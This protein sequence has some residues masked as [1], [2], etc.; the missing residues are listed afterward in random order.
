[1]VDEHDRDLALALASRHSAEDVAASLYRLAGAICGGAPAWDG[2]AVEAQLRW[3]ALA[4]RGPG[5]LE[6]C[7]GASF[8]DAGR[9]LCAAFDPDLAPESRAD[10]LCWEALARHLLCVIDCEAASSLEVSE[11]VMLEWFNRRS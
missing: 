5:I 10:A 8:A 6:A 3:L 11:S 2:L 9:R 4:Q 1:V 7:E